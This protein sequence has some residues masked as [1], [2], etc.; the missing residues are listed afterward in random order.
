MR[1]SCWFLGIVPL[2]VLPGIKSTKWVNLTMGVTSIMRKA[3]QITDKS[4]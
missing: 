2:V 3:V 4:A 1:K